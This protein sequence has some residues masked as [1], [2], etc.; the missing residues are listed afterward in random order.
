MSVIDPGLKFLQQEAKEDVERLKTLEG[1]EAIGFES[2]AAEPT[3]KV[4]VQFT[5]DVAA[6]TAQGFEPRTVA[7][8]VASGMLPLKS[9]EAVAA[10]PQVVRI[11]IARPMQSELNQSLSEIHADLVH[12]G[13]PGNRGSGV[14]IGIIDSG[15]DIMHQSFRR[16]DGETRILSIWDQTLTPADS[17]SHPTGYNYG[18]EYSETSINTSITAGGPPNTVRHT[19]SDI[20]A[21]HGTHVAGIAAGD[22]SVAGNGQPAF[23]FVGVAPEADIIVVLNDAFEGAVGMGDSANT[24]DAVQYI[25]NRAIG[26]NCS[27]VINMSQGDNIGPHDGT[28]LLERGIDNLLGAAGRIM[29]KS[30]GNEG[31][32]RRHASGTVTAGGTQNVRFN[33]PNDNP[34]RDI[35]DIWYD[36]PDRFSITFT[37][38]DGNTST[39]VNPGNTTTL[40]LPNDNTVFVDSTLNNPNNNDNRIFVRIERGTAATI[41]SGNWSFTLTG[42]TISNGRFDAWIDRNILPVPTFISHV[43]AQMTI[44]IPGTS[45]EIITVGSYITTG[46][47]VG[48]LSS[49]SSRGPSRDGR[50]MPTICAPGEWIMSARADGIIRGLGQYHQLAGTSMA[51]PH[52]AGTIA[53]MLEVNRTL[54]QQQV[55]N[56]LVNNART[57][58]FTGTVPNNDW[59]AGKL[60]TQAAFNCAA[61]LKFKFADD[62]ITLKFSDDPITL[63]FSDD[64][65]LKFS[66]DPKLKFSDDPHTLKFSDDPK[67]KFSD[68]PHTLKFSDDPKLKFSDDP[69]GTNPSID[70]VKQ[71]AMDK[72]PGSDF[73]TPIDPSRPVINPTISSTSNIESSTP[74]VLST[75]H[76]SNAWS[77]SYPEAYQQTLDQ[78][79]AAIQSYEQQLQQAQEAAQA[80]ELSDAQ[81]QQAEALYQEY[82]RLVQEYQQMTQ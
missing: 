36:G 19:D 16:P 45:Q 25:F 52:V 62:P 54:T 61:P 37:S 33:M 71:P 26:L 53:L 68:D 15:I 60:D 11:E 2:Q 7:G 80:G 27:V 18:V 29:V 73:G 70:L 72:Q 55:R 24:L 38:P 81:M 41:Q 69:I 5:G 12:A 63:K 8:D 50:Q 20:R 74:F 56:C 30:A 58:I 40:T 6:L 48:S 34:W 9:V 78:M 51:T 82:E 76:H 47:G 22:G 14:I 13:P 67:L 79:K 23:T 44:S 1:A 28:S 39:T 35:I 59:G 65:K 31:V 4:L 49:F 42:L 77:K 43:D 66:D 46:A 64:P 75:P 10:M 32:R 57:D 3:A 17:E 21:G